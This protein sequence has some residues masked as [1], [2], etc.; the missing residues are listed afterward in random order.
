[1][2]HIDP[3]PCGLG[4]PGNET[5]QGA[6]SRPAA[7]NDKDKIPL[8]D[9]EAH[10]LDPDF[11]ALVVPM[12]SLLLVIFCNLFQ[13]NRGHRHLLLYGWNGGPCS[14][15]RRQIRLLL[16]SGIANPQNP[17]IIGGAIPLEVWM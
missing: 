13:F 12:F 11:I 3:A 8:P 1:M 7:A 6:L 5:E 2:P 15:S 9:G 10:V 16:R 17:A 14:G 4:L